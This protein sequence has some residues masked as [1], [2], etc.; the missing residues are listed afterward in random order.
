MLR[1]FLLATVATVAFANI[2]SAADLPVK[3]PAVPYV[4]PYSWTG[5]YIGANL[6]YGWAR[7]SDDLGMSSNLN[8]VIGGGQIGYNWQINNIV[9]GVE[10]DFQGSGERASSNGLFL[11]VPVSVTGRIR[12]F[13]TVR[14]RIG[15]A[16]DRWMVY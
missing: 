10:T 6:G 9:L 3:A 4:A 14:G 11:G 16:W 15:Y 1:K 8:G 2:A 5:F 12:Y 13:G 7:A